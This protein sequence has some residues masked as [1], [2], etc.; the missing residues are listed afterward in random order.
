MQILVQWEYIPMCIYT[1]P[2]IQCF[3]D[4]GTIAIELMQTTGIELS[5][6]QTISWLEGVWVVHMLSDSIYN[7]RKLTQIGKV[8]VTSSYVLD[9]WHCWIFYW[10]SAP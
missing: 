7:W 4:V 1:I 9:W 6:M 10:E 5:E 8:I 3:R 2:I